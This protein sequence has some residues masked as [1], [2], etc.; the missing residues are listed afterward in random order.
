M[1]VEQT[2][3]TMI[4]LD[5][6]IIS[7]PIKLKPNERVAAWINRQPPRS[8]F[9]TSVTLAEIMA[10]IERLP[11]GKRKN[12]MRRDLIDRLIPQM[13]ETRLLPFDAGS[14]VFYGKLTAQTQRAGQTLSTADAQIAA[15]AMKHGFSVATR[16]TVPF[17]AAGVKVINP[18]DAT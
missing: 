8:L 4:V 1:L 2:A 3:K 9:C 13:F 16:D 6:N 14:A 5:T 17:I 15:I 11:N 7:E 18:W 10:G 12:D